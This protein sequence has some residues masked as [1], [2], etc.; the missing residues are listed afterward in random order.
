ML[1]PIQQ[2]WDNELCSL[3]SHSDLVKLQTYLS[4]AVPKKGLHVWEE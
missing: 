1:S 2:H 3:R 4:F